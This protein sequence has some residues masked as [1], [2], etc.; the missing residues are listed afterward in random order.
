MFLPNWSSRRGSMAESK[1]NGAGLEA[2][3]RAMPKIELHAHL[4]GSIRPATLA[5]LA[6]G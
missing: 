1:A 4:H 2:F 6:E 3:C 5:Q